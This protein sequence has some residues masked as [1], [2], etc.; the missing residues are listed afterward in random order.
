MKKFKFN[1]KFQPR[2]V[3][4]GDELYR[5]GI[6]EFN[7]T[8]LRAF[9]MAN[10]DV[11]P[12]EK[13]D[14]EA[15]RTCP[16]IHLNE[17]TVQTADPSAPIV[18]AEISPGRFNVIDGNHRLEKAHRDGVEKISTY[19]VTADQHVA[20]LTSERAYKAYIEYWNS[21]IDDSDGR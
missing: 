10:P 19:R 2:P 3:D 8:K 6:F 18:L 13:V 15:L 14:V 12:P 11:F 21:K 7:I 5:N 4:E 1:K 20:F 9:V 17:S 16:R